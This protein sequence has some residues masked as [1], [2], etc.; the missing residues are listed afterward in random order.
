MTDPVQNFTKVTI[1]TTY[2]DVATSI[3][4]STG[5][6]AL[7]PDPASGNFNLVWYDYTNHP[8]VDT[9]GNV[10]IVRVTAKSSDTLTVTRAQES[11]LASTKN[12]SSATYKM[13]L[14]PTAKTITDLQADTTAVG[15][16]LTTHMSDTSTH[17]VAEIANVATVSA[18]IDSDITTHAGLGNAHHAESHT[19]ASHSDTTATGVELETLTDG[20]DADSLH[21]H[22]VNDA[23]VTNASHTGDVTGATTLTI[24][25][26]KVNDTHIDW[27]TGV[28]QVSAVDIPIADAGVIITAIE[29]EGALQEH[30]TAIDLN[31]AKN[32]NVSTTLSVGTV[33]VNTVAITSDG[34][35]DDVT[36]P[37][38]TVSTAGMLTTAKWAEIVANN[39]KVTNVSTNLSEGTSTETTVNVNS[40]DGTNATLVAASALRAG[41]LTKAKFDE[42]VANNAKITNATHTGDVTGSG[43]LT[44]VDAAVTYAKIQ[45]VVNDDVFLGRI[46]GADGDVEEINKANALT[47]LGVEDGA[48]VTDSFNVAQA[49]LGEVDKNTP[50]DNDTFPIA[51]SAVS[52][53]L[54]KVK[55]SNVKATLKTYF[56]TLYNLYSHPN[57]TGEVTSTGDG[58]T[59]I[60]SDAV[61]YDK[62][63]D[64]SATDKL[65][66]RST[67]GA[68]TIEEISCTAAGRA[69]LDDTDN[70]AQRATLDVDQAGTDNSTDVTLAGT[71]DYIT[72]S[73]QIITRNQIDLTTDVTGALPYNNGGT[74]QTTFAQGDIIYASAVDTLAKLTKGT[75]SEVLAMNSGATAPEWVDT[76]A[77]GRPTSTATVA[78][79]EPADYVTTNYGSDDACIQAAIDYVNG[80][81][82]GSVLIR[83][84]TYT[85]EN[86]I[87]IP[88]DILL[89]G[90]GYSTILQTKA[91]TDL[92]ILQNGDT[93][94]GNDNITI[95]NMTIDGNIA[96]SG[97]GSCILLESDTTNSFHTTLSNLKVINAG[98]HGILLKGHDNLNINNIF[99]DGC[100][101]SKA[102]STNQMYLVRIYNSIISNINILNGY[103]K[104]LKV[105][106]M[107]YSRISNILAKDNGGT[108]I[109]VA[110]PLIIGEAPTT[111]IDLIGCQSISNA[112]HGIHILK[113]KDASPS[114]INI[115]GGNARDNDENGIYINHGDNVH[116]NGCTAFHNSLSG[117]GNFSGIAVGPSS[118]VRFSSITGGSSND[119]NTG[120]YQA[121]GVNSSSN[122]GII[123]S[124]MNVERNLTSGIVGGKT[125][126]NVGYNPVG[127]V[128]PPAVPATTV[129]Y[130]NVY[131]YPCTVVV[132]GGIVTDIDLDDVST[133]LTTG[134]FTIPPSGTINITYSSV[135]T[136][137]WWG[138]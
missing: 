64:T 134:S 85:I 42:I 56:D 106:S 136:W 7:L 110:S 107:Q 87:I 126:N 82:G 105:N 80:L 53:V 96:N 76:S 128:G 129:N 94:N 119:E 23:K 71:P 32:T 26:N 68:G 25:A 8:A 63:Q 48:D 4:L 109:Y 66:G 97:D 54:K 19:V 86:A 135:P 30:R 84:G 9:D 122:T 11:T 37:A 116:L 89:S 24:G 118:D 69:I 59:V 58:A 13:I 36:L 40:S 101:Q 104:G 51:D 114:V 67:I 14:A 5:H 2:D 133:G 70:A 99:V 27:G 21:A 28:N 16:G 29:V 65:L 100:G 131:G 35:A 121:Y 75:A 113:D 120:R 1:S 79:S 45:N 125:Y 91:S 137:K 41:L 103:A 46:S 81:G 44:I 115:I 90:I 18:E 127:S 17:G 12:T 10:E 117:A 77:T 60:S 22:A 33:G 43:A 20:S 124:N 74:G 93:T 62:M 102:Y 50:I 132:S 73:G 88:D 3:V 49:W 47:L 15:A 61:T 38:A 108:G 39:A 57:H 112:G 31:T 72:I 83:E 130:T 123:I 52:N 6:G 55:W 92:S 95:K 111:T 98:D 34:G 78:K 138:L